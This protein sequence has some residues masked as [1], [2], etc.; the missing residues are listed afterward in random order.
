VQDD[1]ADQRGGDLAPL[2]Q[3]PPGPFPRERDAA[4]RHVSQRV[5]RFADVDLVPHL[6]DLGDEGLDHL[7]RPSKR[8]GHLRRIQ[9]MTRF[10]VDDD[11]S[12]IGEQQIVRDMAPPDTVDGRFEHEWLSEDPLNRR[13]EVCEEQARQLQPRLVDDVSAL[14]TGPVKP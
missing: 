11:R 1:T 14:G 8:E 10:D 6:P 13:I 2:G 12:C 5:M 7:S 9:L 3:V 4:L